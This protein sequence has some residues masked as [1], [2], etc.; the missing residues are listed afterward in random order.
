MGEERKIIFSGIQPSGSLTLGN[1]LGAVKNWAALQQEY[2]CYYCVVDLHAI[3]VR[4]DAAALRK[5]ALDVMALLIAAGIDPEKSVLYMQSHVPQ[6]SEL[7]WILSC[8][9]Y[10]GELSRMTQFK[11]KSQRAGEN[12]NAG[13]Y[14]Y[15]VLQAADILLYQADLVPVGVDQKQHVELTRDVAIRFNNLYGDVFTVPA[16]YIPKAGAKIMSLQEPEK[17]MSKSDDN[18]N[19]YI[20]L[21]DEPDVIRRKIKRAVTDSDGQVRFSED[22]PGVSN[23]LSIYSS[24][25]GIPIEQGESEFAS[26]GYGALKERVA[27]AVIEVLAPLQK[28]YYEVRKD[29]AYLTEAMRAG[30]GKAAD[31]AAKT[32]AKVQRKIGL[33][34]TKL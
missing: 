11:E 1:Y 34:P 17:K 14:T 13:L 28:R 7:A 2:D 22:K 21:L 26:A 18:E 8:Y 32:L 6:H 12:I 15:P 33:A 23:L 30:S 31:A 29:K 27:E 24:I 20:A 9:T 16:P 25:R 10:L 3:T 19:A 5:R 4:Q